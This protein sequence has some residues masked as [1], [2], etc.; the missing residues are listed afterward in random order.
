MP[1]MESG[2]GFPVKYYTGDRWAGVVAGHGSVLHGRRWRREVAGGVP[3]HGE[4]VEPFAL[5]KAVNNASNSK[6]D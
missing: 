2:L 6:T 5:R 4:G 3:T 1:N